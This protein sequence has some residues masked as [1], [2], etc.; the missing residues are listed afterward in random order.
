MATD[1]ERLS[2]LETRLALEE[3]NTNFCF[4]LD[5]GQI[6]K[7]LLLFT[8]DAHYSHGTRVSRG[9]NEIATVFARR[10]EA[11]P[12]TARHMYSGLQVQTHSAD[13]ATGTSVCMTFAC[14][15]QAPIVPATP[16]LVADFIDEYTRESDGVWRIASRHIERIFVADGN[17]GPVAQTPD[18]TA[19]AK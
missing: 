13:R 17:K 4:F 5:H 3:L 7:L 12:R 2:R 16:Y 15:G 11:G 9:R 19:G 10:S 8:A 14:D 18:N 6:D 1:S